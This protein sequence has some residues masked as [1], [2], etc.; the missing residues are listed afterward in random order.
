MVD[1]LGGEDP[2]TEIKP[3]SAGTVWIPPLSQRQY[4]CTLVAYTASTS[5]GIVNLQPSGNLGPTRLNVKGGRV[6]GGVDV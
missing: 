4:S 1:F 3:P 5:A 2:V 6:A